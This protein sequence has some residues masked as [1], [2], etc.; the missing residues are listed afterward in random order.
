MH[1]DQIFP[2]GFTTNRCTSFTSLRNHKIFQASHTNTPD[3]DP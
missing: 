2:D 3:E 1:C